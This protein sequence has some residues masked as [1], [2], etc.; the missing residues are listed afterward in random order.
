VTVLATSLASGPHALLGSFVGSWTGTTRTWFEP[1]E[2]L[3]ESET[4][5]TVRAVLD[6]R[7]VVHEYA[8]M[9]Q[10]KPTAG[11]A[12]VGF[13]LDRDRFV[14]AWIDSAH[15]TTAVMLSVGAT[16][17]RDEVSVLGSYD[18]PDGPAWGWRTTFESLSADELLVS[19]YNVPPDAPAY[20]GVE[21]RYR[22]GN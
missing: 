18:V 22:R 8:G 9:L 16:G 20:L 10:G 7:F 13:E 3:D 6:G 21:T 17:V 5:G 2:L 19:H 4:S 15:M 1:E 11:H 14:C 12:V